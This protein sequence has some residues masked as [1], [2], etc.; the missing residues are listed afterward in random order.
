MAMR[1]HVYLKHGLAG[2]MSFMELVMLKGFLKLDQVSIDMRSFCI[3]YKLI[4]KKLK[5]KDLNRYNLDVTTRKQITFFTYKQTSTL[6]DN[7]QTNLDQRSRSMGIDQ[8][9]EY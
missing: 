1:L 7:N 3:E 8:A 4:S 5:R 9:I 6:H 2:Q